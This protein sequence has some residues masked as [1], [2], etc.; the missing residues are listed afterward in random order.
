MFRPVPTWT[1][2]RGRSPVWVTL[3]GRPHLDDEGRF[4]GY[5]GV[6]RDVTEQRL[7][8]ERL[9]ES[10]R[11]HAMMAD[12]A[13]DWFWQTDAEHR[14]QEV[15]P[16][17]RQLLGDRADQA[18][19]HTRWSTF[20]DGASEVEWAAH[21]ADLDAHRPFRGFEFAIRSG[22]RTLRWV[23]TTRRTSWCW[24]SSAAWRA[25]VPA[26]PRPALECSASNGWIRCFWR[27]IGS[28]SWSTRPEA[29]TLEPDPAT[30]PRDA[31]GPS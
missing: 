17:A 12:L 14:L 28:P 10:E 24:D 5:E 27:D 19:G 15:G 2:R 26:V 8:H 22:Q 1:K 16:V 4:T 9:L 31:S 29:K 13:A 18:L 3:T 30:I 11:R 23:S 20:A 6:G 25:C 7:A 21:R